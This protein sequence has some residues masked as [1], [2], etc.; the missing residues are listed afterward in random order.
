[1]AR[2]SAA[3]DI[4]LLNLILTPLD[5]GELKPAVIIDNS[6]NQFQ[7]YVQHS[8]IQGWIDALVE[9]QNMLY[10]GEPPANLVIETVTI[11]DER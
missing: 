5:T 2:N 4:A 7:P 3:R 9:Y 11:N 6:F 8:L 1:M 10:T